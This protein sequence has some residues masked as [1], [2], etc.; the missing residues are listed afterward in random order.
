MFEGRA[1]LTE[2][3]VMILTGSWRLR[4]PN[5]RKVVLH[6]A[7]LEIGQQVKVRITGSTNTTFVGE[8]L[9]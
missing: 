7:S 8:L 1:G 5:N 6:D 2:L 3:G 9:A 4:T